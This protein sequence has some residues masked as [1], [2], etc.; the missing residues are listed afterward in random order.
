MEGRHRVTSGRPCCGCHS[1]RSNRTRSSAYA[2]GS[3]SCRP[4]ATRSSRHSSRKPCGTRR[5]AVEQNPLPIDLEHLAVME[6]VLGAP[7]P[8]EQLLDERA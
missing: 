3:M 4:G 6:E 7:Y 1:S 2:P 5:R 8:A